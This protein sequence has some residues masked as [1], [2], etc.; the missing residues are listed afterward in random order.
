MNIFGILQD[1]EKNLGVSFRGI[2]LENEIK[3]IQIV[4]MTIV[5]AILER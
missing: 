5:L 4:I 1:R 3:H 2:E